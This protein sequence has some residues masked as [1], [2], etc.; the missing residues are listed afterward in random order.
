M[1]ISGTP[2]ATNTTTNTPRGTINYAQATANQTS[3]SAEADLT[4]LTVTFTADSTRRYKITGQILVQQLT[5]TGAATGKITDGSSVEVQRFGHNA[6]FLANGVE[7]WHGTRVLSGISG[8]V[9][10]KLR[11]ATS[12]GTLSVLADTTRPNFILVE[13]IGAA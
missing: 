4:S 9:T 10:Y 13:D 11:A 6:A 8:S 2:E 3:I 5:S 7:V 1:S 12:A